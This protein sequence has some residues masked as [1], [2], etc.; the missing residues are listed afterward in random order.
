MKRVIAMSLATVLTLGLLA[1][2]GGNSKDNAPAADST[3]TEEESTA[4][5][6]SGQEASA[7]N[8]SADGKSVVTNLSWFDT[9]SMKELKEGFEEAYPQYE[10]DLQYAPPIQ[11]YMEKYSVLLA[12]DELTDLYIMGP[13]TREEVIA[14]QCA[15]DLSDL[16]IMDRISDICKR[17][18]GDAEGHVYG[19]SLNAWIRGICYNIDLFEQAGI[20]EFPKTWDEFVDVCKTLQDNGIQPLVCGKDDL[21]DF[22]WGLYT[23]TEIVKDMYT[24]DAINNGTSTFAEK[25]S[26]TFNAWYDGIVEPGYLPQSCLGLTGEQATD[27]FV[28]GQAA[29]IWEYVGNMPDYNVKNPDLKWD[30]KPLPGLNGESMLQGCPGVGYCVA[31]NAKNKE[32]A[33]AYL[34]YVCTKEGLEQYQKATNMI[35]LVDGVDYELIPQIEQYRQDTIDG[36]YFWQTMVWEHPAAILQAWTVGVQDVVAGTLTPDEALES[37][38]TQFAELKAAE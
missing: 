20:Q 38:D 25:Y 29:M 11:Q 1:G 7:D 19:L 9:E 18:N 27:M 8:E 6:D 2:C 23:S 3:G 31:V 36:K 32:G 28:N 14:Y 26:E 21:F 12:A 4:V 5:A 17:T 30:L 15:E 13:D 33:Y 34:D 35:M 22:A 24:D 16:P 10:M 37:F